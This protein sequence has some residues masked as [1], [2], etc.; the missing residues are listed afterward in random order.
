[1]LPKPVLVGHTLEV[2]PDLRAGRE[3]VRPVGVELE[4]VLVEARG[5]VAGQPRVGVVAPGAAHR[6]GLLVDREAVDAGPLEL[7]AHAEPRHAGADDG[8]R[9]GTAVPRT[10]QQTVHP[11]SFCGVS[12]ASTPAAGSFLLSEE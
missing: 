12:L 7:D 10:V 8:H 9:R 5:D 4:R 11:V 6:L 1:M 2:A 3:D